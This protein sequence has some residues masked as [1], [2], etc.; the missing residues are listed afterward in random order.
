MKKPI[1]PTAP[2]TPKSLIEIPK[3]KV[4]PNTKTNNLKK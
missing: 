1:K 2:L 4:T 3:K